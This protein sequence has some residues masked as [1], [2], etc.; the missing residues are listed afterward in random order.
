[1]EFEMRKRSKYQQENRVFNKEEELGNPFCTG[2]NCKLE[3]K[4]VQR[5][6]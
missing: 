6:F 3:S 5:V 1:M 2:I 4:R